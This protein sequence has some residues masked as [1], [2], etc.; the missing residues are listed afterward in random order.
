MY[1]RFLADY[2]RRL[3]EFPKEPSLELGLGIKQVRLRRGFTQEKLAREAEMKS[4]ALKTLENGYAK[5][6]KWA[7]LEAVAGVLGVSVREILMEGREWFPG[8]FYVS[9]LSE[10]LPSGKRKRK[11]REE[12]WFR[13]T[14]LSYKGYS[15]DFSSPPLTS[16]SHFCFTALE[17]EPGK[18]IPGLKLPYPN[19]AA[20]LVQRGTLRIHYD[21]RPE[22]EVV[23]N[24]GFMLRGDKPHDFLNLDRENPVRIWMV[25]S[26]AP[27]KTLKRAAK[28][29]VRESPIGRAINRIRYL[30]SNSK[31]KPLSFAELSCLTGLEENSLQYLENTTDPNQVVYW[32]KI[33]RIAQAL[34]MPLSRFLDLAEGKDEGYF[35]LATAH[36]RALIDYQHYLGIRIRSALFPSP[37]NAYHLSEISIEPKR[38]A[39]RS[40]WARKDEAMITAYV[41]SG[42]LLVEMGKNRRAVL[43]AGESVY[44][45]GSLGYIFTNPS[46]THSSKLFVA[47]YPPIIF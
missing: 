11:Q 1:E 21:S 14:P 3:S 31:T 19:Q 28:I 38:G 5:F 44:F 22:T 9:K 17:I 25:F 23:A 43:K 42:E 6:T 37:I 41:E 35:Y 26:L 30:Y 36:D 40:T 16:P 18:K 4:S 27:L 10:I 13:R 8:N 34:K 12:I 29:R 33:E 24:R 47:T 45:D 46:K 2:R 7:H 20:G 15:V 39:R 32:D